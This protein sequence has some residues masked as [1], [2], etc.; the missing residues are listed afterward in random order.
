MVVGPDAPAAQAGTRALRSNFSFQ[1]PQLVAPRDYNMILRLY[2]IYPDNGSEGKDEVLA[3][4]NSGLET[5]LRLLSL[6]NAVYHAGVV[7]LLHS[8]SV[9]RDVMDAWG[10]NNPE[11]PDL[12]RSVM[13][14]ALDM[15][16]TA[17]PYAEESD[18][19]GQPRAMF[20]QFLGCSVPRDLFN[21][22]CWMPTLG[23]APNIAAYF[24]TFP[25]DFTPRFFNPLVI[26]NY[27]VSRPREWGVVG[28][29]PSLN[30]SGDIK[31]GGAA[32]GLAGWCS[33]QGDSGLIEP[34]TSC[35]PHIHS[36]YAAQVI[37]IL[38]GYFRL[39]AANAPQVAVQ[40]TAWTPYRMHLGGKYNVMWTQPVGMAVPAAWY[41]ADLHLFQPCVFNT[42]HY[43]GPNVHGHVMVGGQFNADQIKQL[44]SQKE[45]LTHNAGHHLAALSPTPTTS[46][47]KMNTKMRDM[48]L[49]RQAASAEK[50]KVPL[51]ITATNTD[52]QPGPDVG[53]GSQVKIGD[54]SPKE[55]D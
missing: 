23:T 55:K 9:T 38:C 45:V 2:G 34:A 4:V 16:P 7:T 11:V 18:A 39:P 5:H 24:H 54:V 20:P 32:A 1:S 35:S 21:K 42:H 49:A 17:D 46:A 14:D 31:T 13:S 52:I 37:N 48:R 27:L 15:D 53:V 10:P 44:I 25:E 26:D 47:P 30:I 12:F 33:V 41:L 8:V 28:P 36:P 29:K 19:F 22:D 6:Y 51:S 40:A 3:Y 43:L 50:A